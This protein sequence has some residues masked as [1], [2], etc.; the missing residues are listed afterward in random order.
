[1]TDPDTPANGWRLERRTLLA[2]LASAGVGSLAG[3]SSFTEREPDGSTSTFNVE[4][5]VGSLATA[6][7]EQEE[8]ELVQQL[9]W[10]VNQ[11]VPI[12][13]LTNGFSPNYYSTDHWTFPSPDDDPRMYMMYPKDYMFKVT[14]D[15]SDQ[16]VL[17]GKTE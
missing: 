4:D 3:C 11:Y 2:T 10:Y 6:T 13:P 12:I 14:Q 8:T 16:A 15:G 1:M 5:A 17:Q 7:D 9:A